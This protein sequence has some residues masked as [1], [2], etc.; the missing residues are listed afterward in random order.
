MSTGNRYL[1]LTSSSH[2]QLAEYIAAGEQLMARGQ[3]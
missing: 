2:D 3:N 1:A